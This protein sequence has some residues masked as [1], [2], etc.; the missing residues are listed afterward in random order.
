MAQETAL[1]KRSKDLVYPYVAPIADPAL[2]RICAS[3]YVAA[4]V[5]HVKPQ[6]MAAA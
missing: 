6:P 5:E 1:Y 3:K 4:L 2:A